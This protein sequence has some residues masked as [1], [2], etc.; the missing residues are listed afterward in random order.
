[1]VVISNTIWFLYHILKPVPCIVSWSLRVACNENICVLKFSFFNISAH[2][3]L[4]GTAS[5]D[6]SVSVVFLLLC[7]RRLQLSV[8]LG[9]GSGWVQHDSEPLG[10]VG[11]RYV[12]VKEM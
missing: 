10:L 1:M 4:G 11:P 2:A 9:L 12:W 8:S 5:F 6:R 7:R 3:P